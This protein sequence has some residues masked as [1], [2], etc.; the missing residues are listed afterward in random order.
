MGNWIEEYGTILTVTHIEFEMSLLFRLVSSLQEADAAR[1][2]C[3]SHF[4]KKH[5]TNKLKQ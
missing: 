5:I 2:Y 4:G 3:F 1:K